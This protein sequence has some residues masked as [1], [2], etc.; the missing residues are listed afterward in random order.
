MLLLGLVLPW[1]TCVDDSPSSLELGA[2]GL[3]TTL[4]LLAA[5]PLHEH[6]CCISPTLEHAAFLTAAAA[7]AVSQ[8]VHNSTLVGSDDALMQLLFT[9]SGNGAV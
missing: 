6:T 1:G 7:L 3:G 8:C 2:L 4:G 5:L 9:W